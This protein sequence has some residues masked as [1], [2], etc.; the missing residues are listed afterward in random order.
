M[1]HAVGILLGVSIRAPR[2]GGDQNSG[3]ARAPFSRVS[4]RAPARGAMGSLS[5]SPVCCS[6]FN[7]RPPRGGRFF[8]SDH[9]DHARRFNPRPPRAGAMSGRR[10]KFHRLLF[11][12][13]PPARGAISISI[14]TRMGLA[15]QSA[16]PARGAITPGWVCWWLKWCFNPRPPRGGRSQNA[17]SPYAW[18]LFQSAPPARGAIRGERFGRAAVTVSIRAPRAGGD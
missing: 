2:A 8:G 3:R 7:P 12:S 4:I 17:Q 5:E 1:S 16:P 6:G 10:K 11:Q 13:A 15:F 18:L 14:T 9:R